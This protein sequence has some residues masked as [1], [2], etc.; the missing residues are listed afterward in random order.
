MKGFSFI[1][2]ILYFATFRKP[3]S[4]SLILT[5]TVPP[6][7]TLRGM[8][9]NALG[10]PRDD[11]SLQDRLKFGI[12]VKK[13]GIKNTEVLKILKFI[14]TDKKSKKKRQPWDM[15]NYPSS[16]LFHEFLTSFV[17]KIYLAS[18]D[19]KLLTNIRERMGNPIRS[20]YLGQSDD[21]IDISEVSSIV[22]VKN[23]MASKFSSIISNTI[24]PGVVLEKLPY[25]FK[26]ANGK[27]F[28]EYRMV[29]IP[30]NGYVDLEKPK[31]GYIFEKEKE[32]VELF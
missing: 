10:L 7:T 3:N 24:I 27:Y 32:V 19:E 28:V 12:S 8:I 11:Y 16:P 6:F 2:E 17:Y 15:K 25:A 20:L 13:T 30:V 4:T 21:L 29:A 23:T 14:K 31:E 26:E 9:S 1:L 22:N 18:E 5:F